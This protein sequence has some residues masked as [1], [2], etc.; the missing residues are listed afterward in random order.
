MK[1]TFITILSCL[2]IAGTANAAEVASNKTS[3]NAKNQINE[4]DSKEKTRRTKIEKISACKNILE[5]CKNAGFFA[6]GFSEGKGLWRNC[7]SQVIEGKSVTLNGKE[8]VIS[9]SATDVSSCKNSSS[10]IK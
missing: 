7:F 8:V 6:G 2:L 3:N 10:S 9:A 1:K 4:I 5:Q